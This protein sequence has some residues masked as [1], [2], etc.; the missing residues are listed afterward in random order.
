[1]MYDYNTNIVPANFFSIAFGFRNIESVF[2]MQGYFGKMPLHY[3]INS[4]SETNNR[5]NISTSAST[6]TYQFEDGRPIMIECTKKTSSDNDTYV[7][8]ES[9]ISIEWVWCSKDWWDRSLIP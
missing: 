3:V 1:M 8:T 7:I 4:T 9:K 2:A 6:Y 5:G